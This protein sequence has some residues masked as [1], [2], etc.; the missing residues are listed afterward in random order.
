MKSCASRVAA[1]DTI[2]A[3]RG[4][5]VSGMVANESTMK[6]EAA[7][8]GVFVIGNPLLYRAGAGALACSP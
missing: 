5:R 7:Q 2:D 6:D 3:R 1:K 8:W 4:A